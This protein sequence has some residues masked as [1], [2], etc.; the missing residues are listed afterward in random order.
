M[1]SKYIV[2]I[3]IF[4]V[5]F[6]SHSLSRN[7]TS[8]DSSWTIHVAMSIIKEKDLDL[9]EYID[10]SMNFKEDLKWRIRDGHYYSFYPVTVSI[11]A[12]PVVYV[13]DKTLQ[14]LLS[15]FPYLDEYLKNL[16]KKKY[17]RTV[18]N[19]N[20]I[21]IYPGV[22]MLIASLIISLASV[23]IYFIARLYLDIKYSLLFVF[24]FAF[25]TSTWSIASRALWQH[26]PSILMLTIVLYLI[27]LSKKNPKLIQFVG[28]FLALSY[29]VRATN[30]ISVLW[31]TTFVFVEYRKYFIKYA[32]G[33]ILIGSLFPLFNILVYHKLFPPYQKI[34]SNPNFFEAMLGNLIS[35]SRGLFLFSPIFLFSI[36]G[37]FIKFNKKQFENLDSTL[38]GIILLH[39]ILMSS[40]IHWW[41]GWAIGYRYLCDMIPYL[42]YFLIP[43][44]IKL[45]DMKGLNKI[46][47]LT[48]FSFLMVFSF[49]VHYRSANNWEVWLWNAKPNNI[50]WNPQRLWD[51]NDIQFLRGIKK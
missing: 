29:F 20:V 7:V 14:P 51:W 24:I 48:V 50:D 43:V 15:A 39:W 46:L 42:M 18:D 28:P 8:T 37:I 22:E 36:Y 13:I 9:D 6:I 35:P 33:G 4:L 19:I 2:P 3:L 41:S 26:C 38:L 5:V 10:D 16:I 34:F 32:L 49:W 44:M 40:Y 21:T 12:L 27:L 45:K 11:M 47:L 30:G 17:N 25:C 23:F 31:I 1:K